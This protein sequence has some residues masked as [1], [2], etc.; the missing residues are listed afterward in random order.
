MS[1]ADAFVKNPIFMSF[2]AKR[3]ILKWDYAENRRFLPAVEMTDS[4]RRTF[5]QSVNVKCPMINAK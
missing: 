4:L 1:N 5:Y 2:R 3:E